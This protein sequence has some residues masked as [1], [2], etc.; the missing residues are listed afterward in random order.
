MENRVLVLGGGVAGMSAAHELVE[1]G[2]DV[3]VHEAKPVAGGKART[4]Y[5][6]GSGTAGRP[7]LPGEHGFRFFPSF[8]QHLPDTMKRIPFAQQANGV[9]DN[10]VQASHYLLADG[11]KKNLPFLVRFPR[12]LAEWRELLSGIYRGRELGIPDGELL[13]FIERILVILTSCRARRLGE[14]EKIDWW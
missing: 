1:R 9:Y 6:P 4:I 11:P 5:V 12:S 10:L 13:F 2:F 3:E 14:Y 7:D 8:Y